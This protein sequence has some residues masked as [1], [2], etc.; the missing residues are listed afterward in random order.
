MCGQEL[1][2][3]TK[4]T[5]NQLK[6]RPIATGLFLQGRLHFRS[7]HGKA[8]EFLYTKARQNNRKRSDGGDHYAQTLDSALEVQTHGSQKW[9]YG[10]H[11]GG[12]DRDVW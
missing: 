6:F 3:L 8:F 10:R 9:Q 11:W 4:E 1:R 2:L 12:D 7:S 5:S